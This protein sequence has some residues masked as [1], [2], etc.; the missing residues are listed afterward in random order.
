[1]ASAPFLPATYRPVNKIITIKLD[2][3]EKSSSELV[4]SV[5]V[6][7]MLSTIQLRNMV[8]IESRFSVECLFLQSSGSQQQGK[9][10]LGDNVTL[11]SLNMKDG[12]TLGVKCGDELTEE[13]LASKG[14]VL[15]FTPKEQDD[16]DHE[17]E[18]EAEDHSKES[19]VMSL[20]SAASSSERDYS[21]AECI[22]CFQ[23][24]HFMFT[25]STCGKQ[26]CKECA[27]QHFAKRVLDEETAAVA[28]D[29]DN[30]PTS[31]YKVGN[32]CPMTR[33]WL[34]AKD[35]LSTHHS[36]VMRISNN[37]SSSSSTGSHQY[38]VRPFPLFS[39]FECMDFPKSP[40]GL[41]FS[42]VRGRMGIASYHFHPTNLL[43]SSYISYAKAPPNWLLENGE[44]PPK[45]K[46]FTNASYDDASRTFKATVEWIP[47]G[48]S[49]GGCCKWEYEIIFD[50][51]FIH[52]ISGSVKQYQWKYPN[53]ENSMEMEEQPSSPSRYPL[54]L[55]YLQHAFWPVPSENSEIEEDDAEEEVAGTET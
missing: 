36:M 32:K 19:N 53:D 14:F 48:C 55:Y 43:E 13:T 38:V 12:S 37:D 39:L 8:E 10:P 23:K 17:T 18:L 41:I 24:A 25:L 7:L 26:I 47:K 54:D 9:L 50:D 51:L 22:I 52:I 2:F 11:R 6:P 31:L 35:I 29:D 15:D 27:L 3:L 28:N 34:S 4:S 44:M 45:R 42:Q 1:M 49:F 21:D 46:Y 16:E 40:H 20:L 5:H 30:V 33:I